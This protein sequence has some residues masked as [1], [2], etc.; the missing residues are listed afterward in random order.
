MQALTDQKCAQY[1]IEQL[2]KILYFFDLVN[3]LNR[4]SREPMMTTPFAV[5]QM[6][7]EKVKLDALLASFRAKFH[8]YLTLRQIMG[9][10]ISQKQ[11][12]N[13]QK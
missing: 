11:K 1:K 2:G 9:P 7:E 12:L 5:Q 13:L 8:N 6:K 4:S 10:H 3:S